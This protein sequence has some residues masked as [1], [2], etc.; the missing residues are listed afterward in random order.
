MN[1]ARSGAVLLTGSSAIFFLS[2]TGVEVRFSWSGFAIVGYKAQNMHDITGY[3]LIEKIADGGM[4]AVWKARQLSLDRMVAIKVLGVSSLPDQEARDRFRKEA[5]IAAKLNHPG[6]VQVIDTGEVAGAAY[7]VME[8]ING[9]TVGDLIRKDGPIP[10]ARALQIIEQVARALAYAWEKECLIHCDIKPDNILVDRVSGM[11]KVADLG[12]ARLIG[13]IQTGADSDLIIG[14]PNYAAP[15]LSAGETDLD[16]RTDLYS[17]GATLYHMVTG[18]LP[19]R[20]APGSQAMNRHETDF[21]EDPSVVNPAVSAPTA[22]LIEKWMIKNRALRTHFWTM[23]LKDIEDVQKGRLP[24]APLPEPG[25]STVLRSPDRTVVSKIKPKVMISPTP[26]S[27]RKLTIRKAEIPDPVREKKGGGS[28]ARFVGSLIS[29]LFTGACLYGVLWYHGFVSWPDRNYLEKEDSVTEP[30]PVVETEWEAAPP[31]SREDTSR[32]G[33]WRNDDFLQGARL[34]NQALADYKTFQANRQN[35]SILEKVS[36]NCRQAIVHFEACRDLAPE[37][38]DIGQ[39]IDQCYGMIANVRHS[40]Q[41]SNEKPGGKSTGSKRDDTIIIETGG[42]TVSAPPSSVQQTDVVFIDDEPVAEETADEKPAPVQLLRV[43]LGDG[44][45]K[46]TAGN[47]DFAM[48]IKR[49]LTRHVQPSLQLEVDASVV[50]YPGITCMTT[51]RE[52]ARTLKQELPIRRPLT[53]PGFPSSGL[54]YYE[55][56][57]DFSGAGKLTLVVDMNDRVVMV[58]MNDDRVVPAKMEEALFSS[59]W[60]AVDFIHARK[61]TEA[62]GLIAHRVR[63]RDNLIRVDT[64][65]A[66]AGTNNTG[67]PP[68]T[69]RVMLMMPVQMAGILLQTTSSSP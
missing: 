36:D 26:E 34:F 38:I 43:A 2:K 30:E 37:H 13:L 22:W 20:D 47:L 33:V 1:S 50:L 5:Q 19:F 6:I 48:D 53:S 46:P 31:V 45:E 55:F 12:L 8:Y 40:T 49:L 61:R 3:E 17:L 18:V 59:N 24:S 16:C 39:Y 54:F 42:T 15:E 60:N 11:V 62:D 51:A 14:T 63:R 57:G 66:A 35:R 68:V 10:E 27:P 56:T 21:L 67:A 7:L 41:L 23:A 65:L 44:W 9:H 69:A 28:V 4:A 64:E 29:L 58:Q 25:A 52:A 32:E